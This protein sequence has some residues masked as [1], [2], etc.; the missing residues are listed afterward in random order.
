MLENQIA[1]AT[2]FQSERPLTILS[3]DINNFSD[4]NH[5]FGHAGGDRFLSFAG[6]IIKDNLRRMDFL[7][8]SAGDEFLVVLPTANEK[9][10]FEIIERIER[11]FVAKPFETA[12]KENVFLKLNFGSAFRR[13]RENA[14]QI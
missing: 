5:K 7:A 9:I 1:E 11:A 3:V 13:G 10:S 8:R 2:R 14:Q 4:I 6:Q 12:E